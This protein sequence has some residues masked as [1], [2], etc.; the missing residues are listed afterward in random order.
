MGCDGQA[1]EGGGAERGEVVPGAGGE[2]EVHRGVQRQ[3]VTSLR[4]AAR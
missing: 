4:C 2:A 3:C 1:L